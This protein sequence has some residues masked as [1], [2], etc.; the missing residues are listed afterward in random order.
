MV[1]SLVGRQRTK[2]KPPL[3][4]RY[5]EGSHFDPQFL[6]HTQYPLYPDSTHLLVYISQHQRC[7]V[8]NCAALLPATIH[9]ILSAHIQNNS[10]C[11]QAASTRIRRIIGHYVP[12]RT[13]RSQH[14]SDLKHEE[15]IG[16][17]GGQNLIRV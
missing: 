9:V 6:T 2:N 14:P 4:S 5:K 7:S 3:N 1:K 10:G 12:G 13:A 15:Y 16:S 8:K 11:L 17:K